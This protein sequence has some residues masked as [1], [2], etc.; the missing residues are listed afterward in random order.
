M[1]TLQVIT[2]SE[3]RL[4]I[5]DLVNFATISADGMA[6]INANISTVAIPNVDRSIVT[7][8][9]V[10]KRNI[11]LGIKPLCDVEEKRQL[12]YRFFRIKHY[13]TLR[14]CFGERNVTI[15]GIVESIDLNPW[16]ADV[17]LQISIIC[18]QP[19]W[20]DAVFMITD[21]SRLEKLFEFPFSIEIPVEI[22]RYNDDIVRTVLNTGDVD[23]GVVI[24]LR[25]TDIVI[26][27]E[28]Y[29]I[30]ERK[31]IKL[32]TIMIGG[33]T[34]T[35]DTR[36]GSKSI[37]LVRAGEVRNIINLIERKNTT[38]NNWFVLSAGENR[39]AYMAQQ[40]SEFLEVS[41]E[42]ANLYQGV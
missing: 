7:G 18:D 37:K 5:N 32:N 12:I 23:T 8:S 4:D 3:E 6:S 16:S 42:H 9:Y 35:I 34:I 38:K 10:E 29:S 41:I 31:T 11:V 21:I 26:N 27:P 24:S 39:F 33:D 40:G 2:E 28:I 14:Y 19:F 1:F 30:D 25:A 17:M 13:V 15:K 36:P 22:A 20:E